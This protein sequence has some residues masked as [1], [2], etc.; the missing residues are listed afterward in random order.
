MDMDLHAMTGKKRSI[1]ALA[2]SVLLAGVHQYLF[3]GSMPGLS[4]PIFVLFFYLFMFLLAR[5]KMRKLGAFE[6]FVFAVIML[7]AMTYL[8]FNNFVFYLLNMIIIPPLIFLHMAYLFSP[9]RLDWS[10]IR[11][12]ID[13]LDH[14]IPQAFRHFP[15]VFKVIRGSTVTRMD[16]RHRQVMGKIAIGVLIA[17]PLLI[18]VILLL[19]SADSQ[20]NQMLSFVPDWF[21]NL[22][23]TGGVQ[24]LLWI[25]FFTILF[26]GY[27]WGFID[28]MTYK[29][30][31]A[32]EEAHS[33]DYG[34]VM[35]VPVIQSKPFRIDPIIIVTVLLSINLVYVL[36]V[37][38][39]FSYLFDV[40]SGALPEGKSY[41]EYARSGFIELITVSAINFIIMLGAL[42]FGEKGSTLL[43]KINNSLLYLLVGCSGVML[44]S[45]YMRLALYEEVYGYTYIRFLVHAFM[46]YLAVLLLIAGVR[47]AFKGV[48]LARYYIVLSLAAYVL[49]NYMGM[50]RII[51][52]NNIE[53]YE[54]TG[55]IDTSYLR[56]LSTDATP[57]LIRFAKDGGPGMEAL[58]QE[59]RDDLSAVDRDFRS[60]NLSSYL[61]ERALER[62]IEK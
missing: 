60:F 54:R 38:V 30:S 28:P 7:L 8:L 20:F 16:Q 6:W 53:R 45:A 42:V 57:L 43:H 39:Q 23:L 41:A 29:Q 11:L 9:R 56:S 37:V 47:I 51:A 22:S 31:A 18:V 14:F 52:A 48:P 2:G 25:A 44:Y 26:F 33:S 12:I 58:L 27:L 40:L 50:D 24:R 59:A 17:L 35:F 19:S 5:D 13:A 10:N 55:K 1:I 3:Y 4:Y 49:V 15:T 36:F 21:G 34:E 61:A 32:A 62:Y 46:I